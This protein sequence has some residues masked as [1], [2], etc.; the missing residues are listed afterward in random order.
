MGQGQKSYKF[1]SIKYNDD[2]INTS[3]SLL[4]DAK[5]ELNNTE[6]A[7][8][9]GFQTLGNARGS[10]WIDYQQNE[11][12]ITGFPE[13]FKGYINELSNSLKNKRD[14][15][16]D[17]RDPKNWHKRIFATFFMGVSKFTEGI[18]TVGENIFFYLLKYHILH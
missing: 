7:L 2:N 11:S 15:I 10:N 5:K 13:E 16:E 14:E 12:I 1:G 17:Y 6:A 8:A 18:L 3:L 9:K 4:E